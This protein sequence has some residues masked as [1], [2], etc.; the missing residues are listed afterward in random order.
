MYL[1]QNFFLQFLNPKVLICSIRYFIIL[2]PVWDEYSLT[3]NYVSFMGIS[4]A[5]QMSILLHSP[6]AGPVHWS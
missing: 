1:I 4:Q 6:L 2:W 3:F 5:Y